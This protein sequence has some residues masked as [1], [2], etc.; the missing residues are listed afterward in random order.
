MNTQLRP[1]LALLVASFS[2]VASGNAT[3]IDIRGA[4]GVPRSP[5][6]PWPWSWSGHAHT[7]TWGTSQDGLDPTPVLDVLITKDVVYVQGYNFSGELATDDWSNTVREVAAIKAY[8]RSKGSSKPF[9]VLG[10]RGIVVGPPAI[11]HDPAYQGFWLTDDVGV[12]HPGLWDFRNVS[13]R[14]FYIADMLRQSNG[15]NCDGIFIDTGDAVP[16]SGNLTVRS[17]REMFNATA[18]LWRELAIAASTPSKPFVITPSLK[19]HLGSDPDGDDGHLRCNET[20]PI[21][22][23]CAP[24]GEEVIYAILDGVTWAPHRQFNI[25]SRD[26]GKDSA[27]CVAAVTTMIGQGKQGPQFATC[28]ACNRSS[29]AG[30]A[31]FNASFA[32]F[33]I[34]AEP[35][36]YFGAGT[37]FHTDPDWNFAWPALNR[38][39]GQPA[40]AA[41]QQ[42]M[43]FTREFAHV[44]VT[45]DCETQTGT[46]AWR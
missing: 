25:P 43:V 28:N 33:L 12:L 35:G 15:S 1:R 39:I 16:M 18:L 6:L 21:H 5:T 46:L 17:R 11:W 7:L 34:A 37:H 44:S 20:T 19:D 27:G 41:V 32:A 29:T 38:P 10:Y 40:G 22:V 31:M 23:Q 45:M 42:G 13:A 4:T 8:Q 24:Y 36:S 30:W 26:F 9:A 3:K 14:H 2:T